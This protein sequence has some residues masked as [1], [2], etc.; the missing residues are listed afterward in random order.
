LCDVCVS[1]ASKQVG[2]LTKYIRQQGA[3]NTCQ[4][5]NTHMTGLVLTYTVEE[6]EEL[7]I[8]YL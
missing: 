5:H 7:H 2:I 6:R 3:G 8:T 1:L 4:A